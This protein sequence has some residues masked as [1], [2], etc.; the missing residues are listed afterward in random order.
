[1][2]RPVALD[3]S[4]SADPEGRPL[5]FRWDLG[6]GT[7]A[8]GPRVV[9]AFD[10]PGFYRVGL[11]ATNG[12]LCDLAWRDFYAVDDGEEWGTEGGA[13]QWSW[14]DPHSK[15]RFEDDREVRIAGKSSVLARIDPYGGMM[16]SLLY[17]ASRKAGVP[18]AGKTSL[19]FWVKAINEHVPAWQGLQ[20]VVTLYESE[21]NF[22]ALTPKTDLMSGRPNNED[23]EGWSYFVVPLAGSP[24][25]DRKGGLPDRLN[26]VTL[27]FDS[28][29][30]PPLRIWID[31]M[32]L[33]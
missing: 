16:A 26:Y 5:Q 18:L 12:L 20:P 6:D 22:A 17:P 10:A 33:R 11:T 19:V 8:R 28:W 21:A 23:R 29:G 24:E 13:A 25:W 1:V 3:A 2:G 4:A 7:I 30:A 9:H 32:G 14:I 15:V 27:G 31:G